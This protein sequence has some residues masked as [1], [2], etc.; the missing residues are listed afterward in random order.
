MYVPVWGD[1]HAG[2]AT[3][4]DAL[5]LRV[6]RLVL[7]DKTTELNTNT[8]EATD[9]T[10]FKLILFL[11]NVCCIS[12]FLQQNLRNYATSV[13]MSEYALYNSRSAT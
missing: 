7:H 10:S 12:D 2:S 11:S 6:P 3:K 13:L 8:Y 9:L 5:L 1:S 4:L